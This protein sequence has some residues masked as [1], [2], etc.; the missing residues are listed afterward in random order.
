MKKFGLVGLLLVL[1]CAPSFSQNWFPL[2]VGNRV[3]FTLNGVYPIAYQQWLYRF[4]FKSFIVIDSVFI[5]NTKYFSVN[6]F[7]EFP[8]GTLIRYNFDSLKI[9]VF[10]ND[11]EYTFMDFRLSDGESLLQ[12]QPDGSILPITIVSGYK[13]IMGD[14]IFIKGFYRVTGYYPG[15]YI[16]GSYYFS[17]NKGFVYQS[18]NSYWLVHEAKTI[19][20][21]EY[22]FYDYSGN[23]SHKKHNHMADI[24]FVPVTFLPNDPILTENFKIMHPLSAYSLNTH[25]ISR[26]YIED[27]YLEGYYTNGNDTTFTI[28]DIPSTTIVDYSLNCPIDTIKY[29]LGYHFFYRIVAKDKG[30][31][32]SYYYKP[33]SGY[34]KL[35]WRNITSSTNADE[36]LFPT[37]FSLE[38]NYPNPFNP[39]TSIQYSINSMQFVTLK[40]YDVLGKEVATLVNEEKSAGSYEVKFNSAMLSTTSLPSGVYFYQLSAGD[41]IETKKM[42]LLK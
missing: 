21:I 20:M 39:S 19:T 42:I 7:F 18:E 30:I 2:E 6:G 35:Y 5:N 37:K 9:I 3:D 8:N 1:F 32:P 27:A 15:S 23:S 26:T 13:E 41:F 33:Y 25:D 31:I 34:Y 22:L 29:N 11:S 12:I 40:V 4:D 17:I 38:Q 16:T 28:L 24:Q 36:K 14:T 10:K